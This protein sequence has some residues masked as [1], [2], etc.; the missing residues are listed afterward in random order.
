MKHSAQEVIQKT[1]HWI[2]NV[3]IDLNLCP[4]ASQVF[5]Q[6]QIQYVVIES[7]DTKQ[8][9]HQLADTFTFLDNNKQT[10]T[11]LLI[12]PQSY[13]NFDEYLTMLDLS[14]LL[15]D[16]L[17]YTG[18]YQLASFHPQYC[19][20]GCNNNDA[21]NFSNRSP[22]PMLHILRE[23]SIEKVLT[24]YDHIEDVPQNNI[25]KLE[26]IGFEKMQNTLHKIL[27]SKDF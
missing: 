13:S 16:D 18:I 6:D 4:F 2:Q 19:F 27:N 21:E 17:S 20:E 9:L 25:N 8:V 7:N 26:K 22:Y 3:V 12:F 1:K 15:L 23:S 11:S 10:E 14:N 24:S 5:I